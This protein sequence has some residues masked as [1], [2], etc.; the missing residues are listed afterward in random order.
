M[1]DRKR[2]KAYREILAG[3]QYHKFE[4]LS[5]VTFGFKRGS[6]IDCRTMLHQIDTWVKREFKFKM[7][8]F[9]VEVWENK[10]GESDW[11]VHIHMIWNAPYIKQALIVERVQKYIGD[12]KANVFIKLLQGD[13]KNSAR[14]LMQYLGNQ[15]GK[16]YYT[17]SREWLPKGYNEQWEALKHE[18]YEKVRGVAYTGCKSD[19]DVVELMSHNDD[20]WRFEGLIKMMNDWVERKSLKRWRDFD[21]DEGVSDGI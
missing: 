1:L 11:R 10:Q 5:F 2:G 17:K 12:E 14:Y 18:F 19:S 13:P 6:E 15:E 3:L 16:V 20:T 7:D 4:K 21:F 8:Y 9:R